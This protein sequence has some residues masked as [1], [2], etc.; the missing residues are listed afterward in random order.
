MSVWRWQMKVGTAEMICRVQEMFC[1]SISDNRQR[2]GR[3][4]TAKDIG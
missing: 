2:R 1:C 4:L 3:G